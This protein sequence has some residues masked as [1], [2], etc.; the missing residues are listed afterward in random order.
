MHPNALKS[1]QG[2][3]YSPF[4]AWP[5]VFVKCLPGLFVCANVPCDFYQADKNT[6]SKTEMSLATDADRTHELSE[7]RPTTSKR[8]LR[9]LC[10]Q[11]TTAPAHPGAHGLEV[12]YSQPCCLCSSC[13]SCDHPTSSTVKMNS[14]MWGHCGHKNRV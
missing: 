2:H 12:E 6:W 14:V 13:S 7:L 3:A 1:T 9:M 8:R 5:C 4:S 11:R 10:C